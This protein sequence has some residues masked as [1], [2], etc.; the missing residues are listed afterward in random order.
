MRA[1]AMAGASARQFDI[2]R[3]QLALARID[4]EIAAARAQGEAMTELA[5]RR[6]AVQARIGRAMEQVMNEGAP[7]G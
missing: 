5:A 7:G 1:S 6:S 3:E 2:E 4:R